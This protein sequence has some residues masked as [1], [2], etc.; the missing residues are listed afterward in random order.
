MLKMFGLTL[1]GLV[2]LGACERKQRDVQKE[3]AIGAILPL[4]G[5]GAK[6]GESARNA[7]ELALS[8]LNA[9]GGINGVTVRVIL[10]D[11]EG[12]QQKGVS[13]FQKLTALDRVPAVIGGLFSSVTRAMAPVANHSKVVILSPTSSNPEITDAGDY[14]F[15]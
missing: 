10:E 6:Y 15:R 5:D 3:I 7:I 9:A 8:E 1:T 14:V 13:A 11:S 12:V 4:T 2:W